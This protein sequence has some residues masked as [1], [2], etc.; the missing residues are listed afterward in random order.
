MVHRVDSVLQSLPD[1]KYPFTY[2]F[3]VHQKFK[4]PQLTFLYF[5]N[6]TFSF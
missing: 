5:K 1:S 3:Q 2:L 4:T 6:T